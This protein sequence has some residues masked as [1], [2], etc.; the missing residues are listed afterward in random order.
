MPV[1]NKSLSYHWKK[2]KKE[3]KDIDVDVVDKWYSIWSKLVLL[4]IF[5]TVLPR[6]CNGD[7]KFITLISR[8]RTIISILF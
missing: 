6:T 5:I 4:E 3:F 2:K 8:S 7:Y 1:D